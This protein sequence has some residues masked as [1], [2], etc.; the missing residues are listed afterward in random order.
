MKKVRIT[1]IRKASYP[2]LMAKYENPIE[3]ACDVEEGMVWVSENAEKPQ[4][5]CD[6]AWGEYGIFRP[7]AGQG[8]RQFLRRLDERSPFRHDLLQRRLQTGEFLY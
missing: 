4:G 8:R 6:S 7:G 3:H 2:D 5:F 1:A